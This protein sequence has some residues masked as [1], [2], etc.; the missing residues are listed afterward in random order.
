MSDGDLVTYDPA[1]GV[2]AVVVHDVGATGVAALRASGSWLAISEPRRWDGIDITDVVFVN[3]RTKKVWR[4]SKQLQHEIH[5]QQISWSGNKVTFADEPAFS[6]ESDLNTYEFDLATG[7]VATVPPGPSAGEWPELP[8]RWNGPVRVP[9]PKVPDPESAQGAFW[10]LGQ[11]DV[12]RDGRWAVAWLQPDWPA[13]IDDLFPVYL[14]SDDGTYRRLP[15][16]RPAV[17]A[18]TLGIG[19]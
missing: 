12:S 5:I 8:A 4:L 11:A 15:L 1:T 13:P 19:D 17:L 6:A 18:H 14:L 16:E 2:K 3:V 10:T 7:A 9:S